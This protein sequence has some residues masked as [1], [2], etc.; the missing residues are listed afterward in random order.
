MRYDMN[1]TEASA[2]WASQHQKRWKLTRK[3][4]YPKWLPPGFPLPVIDHHT[5]WRDKETDE[6]IIVGHP[7]KIGHVDMMSLAKFIQEYPWIHVNLDGRSAYARVGFT[8]TVTVQRDPYKAWM[9][10]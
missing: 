3:R 6:Q 10:S 8:L 2:D 9:K 1:A 5:I 7:Y 4:T